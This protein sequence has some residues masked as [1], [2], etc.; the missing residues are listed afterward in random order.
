MFL[1]THEAP[2]TDSSPSLWFAFLSEIKAIQ[3]NF[4][5]D[6]SLVSCLMAK[7]YLMERFDLAPFD[8]AAKPQGANGL[9]IDEVTRA[10]DR[11]IGE[12]KTTS[13]HKVT[14]F[15]AAQITSLKKDF[16]K[17]QANLAA[18]KFMF[19]TDNRS[20]EALRTGYSAHLSG[21][22]IV[23]LQ[24]GDEYPVAPVNEI[25]L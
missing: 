17:L 19:V 22:T 21:V 4:S 16:V 1:N 6:L 5:N 2:Q 20:F 11:I 18:R 7:H 10:G 12:I 14:Q 9:D 23:C 3:G 8:V 15:G 25:L 13:P 24:T